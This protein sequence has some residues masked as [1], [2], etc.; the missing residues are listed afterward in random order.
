MSSSYLRRCIERVNLLEVDLVVLTG[1]YITYDLRGTYREKVAALLGDIESRFGTYACLGNHDYGI[2]GLPDRKT[3]LWYR[4]TLQM[5]KPSGKLALFFTEVDGDATVYVNGA[6]AGRS[7][8][9]RGPFE[10]DITAAARPGRNVV[11]VRV[12]HSSITELFLGGIL[13]PVLLIEKGR[14]P[15][16]Q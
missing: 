10:A 1:D 8:R 3:I 2:Q 11:A 5:P 12:D 16:T 15:L 13:R 6:E 14:A 4:R 7:E 9:K